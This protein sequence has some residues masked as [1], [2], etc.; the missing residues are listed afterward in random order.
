MWT[1]LRRRWSCCSQQWQWQWQC[2]L[3][4][5]TTNAVHSCCVMGV[6]TALFECDV[7]G[8]QCDGVLLHARSGSGWGE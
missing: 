5:P 3:D 1:K 6:C 2:G 7:P 8:V 4:E